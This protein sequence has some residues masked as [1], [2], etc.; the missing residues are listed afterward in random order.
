M[1]PDQTV[2]DLDDGKRF[3]LEEGTYL[4]GAETG[5]QVRLTGR[6]VSKRHAELRIKR[7]LHTLVDLEST[8]GTLING[9]RIKEAYL[10]PRDIITL[11]TCRL[12]FDPLPDEVRLSP[13][14]L[15]HFGSVYGTSLAM[16]RIF[17]TLQRVAPMLTTVLIQG[18]SGTGKDLLARALHTTGSRAAAPLVVFDCS[19]VSPELIASELFGHVPGA[20]TGA[21]GRRKGA[22]ESAS[23]GT[24]FLEELPLDLQPKLL[25]ALESREVRPVGSDQ[26]V[27]VDVR[28]VAAT[29][30]S[31]QTMVRERRFREDLYYRL[32]VVR[33]ELP[34]LRD[35]PEDIAGI[36]R[37]LMLNL[38][39]PGGSVSLSDHALQVLAQQE[40][41]GNVRELRNVLERSIALA[42]ASKLEAKDLLLSTESEGGETK[43]SPVPHGSLQDNER[44]LILRTLA[45]CGGNQSEAARRL[46]I[47]RDTLRRKMVA[48]GI[49]REK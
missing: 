49:F 29:N 16:R 41:P 30:Q 42:P 12:R 32:A 9:A 39:G 37:F 40:W 4:L 31:L 25:R 35:R 21:S 5:A 33:I 44:E 11:G 17:A 15:D 45:A 38:G 47:H 20:F 13:S 8:N 26:T 2:P 7:G 6:G 23:G 36:V 19:A 27:P 43:G 24:L 46:N 48:Y 28:V 22:F 3:T 10:T 18:E 1:T 34:P 14:E